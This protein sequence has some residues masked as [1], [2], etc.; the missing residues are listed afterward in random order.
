MRRNLH[1]ALPAYGRRCGFLKWRK[2]AKCIFTGLILIFAK[3]VLRLIDRHFVPFPASAMGSGSSSS[4]SSSDDETSGHNRHHNINET[5]SGFHILELHAPTM[6]AGVS[7][8]AVFGVVAG[9]FWCLYRSAR[10]RMRR[11]WGG[12][13][14]RHGDVEGGTVSVRRTQ[15]VPPAIRYGSGDDV[16]FIPRPT[17]FTNRISELPVSVQAGRGGRGGRFR[18]NVSFSENHHSD[19]E[20]FETAEDGEEEAIARGRQQVP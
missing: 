11:V 18:R 7:C 12:H 6:G 4:S 14:L 8:I 1:A 19:A 20:G 9:V 13:A 17:V 16:F 15:G 10:T 5:S 3:F 2:V